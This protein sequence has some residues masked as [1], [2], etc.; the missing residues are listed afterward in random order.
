MAAATRE[1][2]W[3]PVRVPGF[4]H[5][6]VREGAQGT[7]ADGLV[8]GV[9]DGASF[10]ARYAIACDR[11]WRPLTVRVDV[12]GGPSLELRSDGAGGWQGPRGPIPVLAECVDVD[13][14][15]SPFTNTI[16][17]RRLGLAPLDSRELRVAHVD[18]P[19]LRVAVARQR[20]TCLLRREDGTMHRYESGK[21]RADLTADADGLVIEYPRAWT[22][23]W[24]R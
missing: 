16:P 20:Y 18:V 13:L 15:M 9:R 11:E 2:M 3:A 5:C 4:E 17:I 19:S 23:V 7:R 24:P 22:R 8:I 21:F 12:E 10:R 1:V 6:T 14:S